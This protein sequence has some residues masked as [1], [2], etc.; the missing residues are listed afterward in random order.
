MQVLSEEKATL[1]EQYASL[2]ALTAHRDL[3]L[4]NA[5][6]RSLSER[7]AVLQERV[8]ESDRVC[9]VFEKKA[10]DLGKVLRASQIRSEELL[11]ENMRYLFIFLFVYSFF[12]DLFNNFSFC[13]IAI[14]FDFI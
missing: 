9:F 4:S 5:I 11:E 14:Y 3:Q 7:T 13:F 2:T 1:L 8:V 6:E 10:F 12:I